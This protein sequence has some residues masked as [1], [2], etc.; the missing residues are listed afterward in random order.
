MMLKQSLS[1]NDKIFIN[2]KYSYRVLFNPTI[3]VV[4]CYYYMVTPK[5]TKIPSEK[6]PN[7]LSASAGSDVATRRAPFQKPDEAR[8]RNDKS[9]PNKKKKDVA[10][11]PFPFPLFLLHLVFPSPSSSRGP[12]P[13]LQPNQASSS[14][15][16]PQI[17]S[18]LPVS[19]LN[20]HAL[21]SAPSSR[22]ALPAASGPE[23]RNSR[24]RKPWLS[25]LARL[26]SA[27]DPASERGRIVL[28]SEG[29]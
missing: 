11:F 16:P 6:L 18:S 23:R 21:P 22:R 5:W 12:S 9:A 10:K 20:S 14:C 2:S 17:C 4:A 15:R 24:S 7:A 3:T 1:S 26:A 28:P 25:R 29:I 13:P 8:G 27:R 19:P